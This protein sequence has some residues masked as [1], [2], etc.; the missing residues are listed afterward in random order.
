MPKILVKILL[1]RPR[2]SRRRLC[3]AGLCRN[4][5]RYAPLRGYGGVCASAGGVCVGLRYKNDGGGKRG[6]H[7][8]DEFCCQHDGGV[9]VVEAV[10]SEYRFGKPFD[11]PSQFLVFISE[12][13]ELCPPDSA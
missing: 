11:Q 9:A 6:L 10:I 1:A 5:S 8:L 7:G 4:A 3:Q 13:V 2:E 12:F